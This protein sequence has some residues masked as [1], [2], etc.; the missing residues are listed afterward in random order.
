LHERALH[1]GFGE[2][3]TRALFRRA[4]RP[5]HG[6]STWPRSLARRASVVDATDAAALAIV[7]YVKDGLGAFGHRFIA[8]DL[9]LLRERGGVLP[10]RVASRLAEWSLQRAG[11]LAYVSLARDGRLGASEQAAWAPLA[12]RNR[13]EA[14]WART[15]VGLLKSKPVALP[16]RGA[17]LLP[18]RWLTG[19]SVDRHPYWSATVAALGISARSVGARTNAM[20]LSSAAPRDPQGIRRTSV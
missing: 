4:A 1:P 14:Q 2:V 7:H 17:A 10:S 6:S 15:M 9:S 18:R 11:V 16:K 13:A 20:R 8:Q 5:R 3:D 12:P 19:L